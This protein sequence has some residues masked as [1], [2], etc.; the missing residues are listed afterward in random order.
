MFL[1]ESPLERVNGFEFVFFHPGLQVEQHRAEM[2]GTMNEQTT[3]HMCDIGPGE[4]DF[5]SIGP[6]MYTRHVLQQPLRYQQGKL[7]IPDG[8]GLGGQV[9]TESLTKLRFE[10][11]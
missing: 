8:P 11:P 1:T 5:G 3:A 4:E 10:T 6:G 7:S 9:D 2:L